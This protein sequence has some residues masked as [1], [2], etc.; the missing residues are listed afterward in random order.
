MSAAF[1]HETVTDVHHWNDN[2]FSFKTTRDPGLRFFRHIAALVWLCLRPSGLTH[3]VCQ[4]TQI[5]RKKWTSTSEI[6]KRVSPKLSAPIP[7]KL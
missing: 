3:V 2:L 6:P 5:L 7:I 4:R 1:L